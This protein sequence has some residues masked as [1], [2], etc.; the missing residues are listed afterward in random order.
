[1]LWELIWTHWLQACGGLICAAQLD[2]ITNCCW[3][4]WAADCL[5]IFSGRGLWWNTTYILYTSAA[6][7]PCFTYQTRSRSK[8][9][10]TSHL[11][12]IE[13]VFVMMKEILLNQIHNMKMIQTDDD[14]NFNKVNDGSIW[15]SW[16][17][18]CS[19]VMVTLHTHTRPHECTHKCTPQNSLAQY[20]GGAAQQAS[21]TQMT[22]TWPLCVCVFM[23]VILYL[24]RCKDHF[25]NK[26]S[27]LWGPTVHYGTQ[28][29]GP[30]RGSAGFGLVIRFKVRH[31][32]V[33][34][35]LKVGL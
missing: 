10:L 20:T 28:S 13:T 23:C 7:S 24:I 11:V 27:F 31:V 19:T 35:R 29:L 21:T 14:G 12:N 1:M 6:V 34:V 16:N 26:Y 3:S 9:M 25:S 15:S 2:N 32:L 30:T 17:G 4:C 5:S 22:Q 8:W 18:Y 33:M